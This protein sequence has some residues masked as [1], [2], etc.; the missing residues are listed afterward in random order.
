MKLPA[1]LH[2]RFYL[3]SFDQD[4]RRFGGDP[5]VLDLALRAAKV[6]DLYLSGHLVDRGGR[7]Y[8]GRAEGPGDPVLNREVAQ[9][10]FSIR[11]SW[12]EAISRSYEPTIRVVRDQL[13]AG[14]WLRPRAYHT[15]TCLEPRDDEM[16][17]ALVRTSGARCIAPSR[18]PGQ[19]AHAD[20][21]VDGDA[22]GPLV[23]QDRER[24][25]RPKPPLPRVG[26]R[27]RTPGSGSG[28]AARHLLRPAAAGR[29]HP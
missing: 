11:V 12:D 21:G 3:L 28:Q 26:R 15:G 13:E 27:S 1:T 9:F 23:A 22:R 14:E 18:R 8:P 24:G 2:G 7:P 20:A 25:G 4:R 29:G 10:G 16:V 17:A 5:T 19:S 6:A